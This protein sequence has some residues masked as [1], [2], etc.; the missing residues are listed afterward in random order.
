M[1]VYLRGCIW[2]NSSGGGI[3]SIEAGSP[4]SGEA[5]MRSGIGI[6]TACSVLL[7]R[8]F[9]SRS[10]GHGGVLVRETGGA[11]FLRLKPRR[12]RLDS[13]SALE[14]EAGVQHRLGVYH[15]VATLLITACAA[16]SQPAGRAVAGEPDCSFRSPTSCWT[17][18]GR[19]PPPR[20]TTEPQV[21]ETLETP[22]SLAT[23]PDSVR[24][25]Q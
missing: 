25:L 5:S 17:L 22:P 19:F 24:R 12:S 6:V 1:D 3:F 13:S 14:S 23:K 7:I 11:C 10:L 15:L 9:R 16:N 20:A 4:G 21:P 2:M 18:S 8:E